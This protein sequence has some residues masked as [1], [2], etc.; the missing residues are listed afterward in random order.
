MFLL[1]IFNRVSI[2]IKDCFSF[3]LLLLVIGPEILRLFLNQSY[4]K[5]KR[6]V[7][8]SPSFSRT[9][10]NLPVFTL[11]CHWLLLTFPFRLIGCFNNCDFGFTACDTLSVLFISD[12]IALEFSLFSS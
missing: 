5:L 12:V 10:G 7:T 2:I 6:I 1:I 11:S 3:A 4:S 9:L 8:W